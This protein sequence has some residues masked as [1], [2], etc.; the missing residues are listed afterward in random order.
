MVALFSDFLSV[1]WEHELGSLSRRHDV[2]AVRVSDPLDSGLPD[3]GLISLED[4][5]T[6]LRLE[7]PT[8]HASFRAAWSQWH[9][10]RADLWLNLCRRAGAAHLELPANANAAA[11]LFRFFGAGRPGGRGRAY[12]KDG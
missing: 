3:L 10:E 1:N 5:E 6:R 9:E 8:A 11:A 2:I 4:P 12:Y 7:A